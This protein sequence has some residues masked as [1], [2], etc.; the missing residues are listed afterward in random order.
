[1]PVVLAAVNPNGG[2]A[3]CYFC[4]SHAGLQHILLHCDSTQKLHEF[5]VLKA[6]IP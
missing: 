2:G 4:G 6:N 3:N 1:M 5:V